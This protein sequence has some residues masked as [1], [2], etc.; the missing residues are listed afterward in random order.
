VSHAGIEPL[1]QHA[2]VYLQEHVQDLLTRVG[3]A[4]KDLGPVGVADQRHRD[5]ERLGV[6]PAQR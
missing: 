2:D 6:V 4:A 1:P 5:D 3:Q